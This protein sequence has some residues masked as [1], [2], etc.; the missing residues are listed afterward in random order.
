MRHSPRWFQSSPGLSTG[1]YHLGP[2]RSGARHRFNPRPAFR[3]DATV[4]GDRP[5]TIWL[6]VSILARPF[7]RTLQATPEEAAADAEFQSSPGLSTGRYTDTLTITGATLGFNPRPA[8]RPDATARRW[9][10]R[11][12]HRRFNPR[13]AF[14]PDATRRGPGSFPR[15]HGFNPRP[16]FR[17]DATGEQGESI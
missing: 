2:A 16:A 7:D 14:R 12:R 5:N 11:E 1:R 13:P 4:Y 9:L 17:P 10:L 15:V 6:E 8:F 3:P